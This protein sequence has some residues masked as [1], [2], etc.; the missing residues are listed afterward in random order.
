MP[1]CHPSLISP[2]L[3]EINQRNP[4]NILDVG[5]GT[6]KWGSLIREYLDVWYR[7]TPT[8][9]NLEPGT[10]ILDGIEIHRAYETPLWKLY[11]TI[12]VGDASGLISQMSWHD[13]IL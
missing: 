3:C 7:K 6:G 4:R 11:N 5:I 1:T 10:V 8:L 9:G 13:L 2:I 12:F